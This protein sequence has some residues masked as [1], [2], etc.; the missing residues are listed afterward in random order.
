MW[1]GGCRERLFVSACR[2]VFRMNKG[3]MRCLGS[4]KAERGKELQIERKKV[5][6]INR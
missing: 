5:R 1:G 6:V 2:T 4:I 3:E